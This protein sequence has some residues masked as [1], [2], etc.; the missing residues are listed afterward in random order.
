M[1][2]YTAPVFGKSE[3][4]VA[5]RLWVFRDITVKRELEQQLRQAQ[6][7]E[8]VGRL[9]GGV[10]HDFN[11]LLT[12]IS[13]NLALADEGIEASDVSRIKPYFETARKAGE[14]ARALVEKLLR[15]SRAGSL[16]V[17][18]CDL[19]EIA[20]ETEDLIRHTIDPS[21]GISVE[22]EEGVAIAEADPNQIQQVVMNLCVNAADAIRRD[23]C[24]TMK[25]SETEFDPKRDPARRDSD[26]DDSG[27]SKTLVRL[28]VLDTGVGIEPDQL[29]KIFEPFFTTKEQGKG[30]GLGLSMCQGIVEQHGGWITVDSRPGEGA[31]F[32]IFLP[33]A[34]QRKES[35]N[36]D[37][38]EE[39]DTVPIDPTSIHVLVVDDESSVRFVAETLLRR[40]G[41]HVS[42][43]SDGR[44]AIEKCRQ[45]S[46]IDIVL[47]DNTM[48]V[49]TGR[50]AFLELAESLPELPVIICSGYLDD[51]EVFRS[52]RGRMPN[53]F[54]QK[55]YPLAEL[56]STL[57]SVLGHRSDAATAATDD[58]ALPS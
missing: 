43:A 2:V 33:R 4:E 40:E 36:K 50:E 42:T 5:A 57:R 18:R 34:L 24:I 39:R 25:V 52:P 47:M 55:P 22:G 13:G 21:I 35:E 29:D 10:A 1:S 56:S 54:V 44:E 51:L 41:Y 23:G 7:M 16:Q 3:G 31:T 17:E 46:G 6:K 27:E 32:S 45:G 8:A 19:F 12:G 14:R 26:S 28:D 30:T 37:R 49:M 9:A 38:P 48:P 20:R 11:N 58:L 15:Y 53:A